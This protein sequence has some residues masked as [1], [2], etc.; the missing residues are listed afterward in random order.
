MS[1]L[2][3]QYYST[4]P[5]HNLPTQAYEDAAGYDLYAAEMRTILPHS[6]ECVGIEIH[7]AIP[8]GFFAKLFSRSGLLKDYL[9]ICEGGV[10]D[11]DFRGDLKVMLVNLSDRIFHVKTGDKIAHMVFMKKY[12]VNFKRVYDL[13]DLGMT[14]RGSSGFSLSSVIK[15]VKFDIDEESDEKSDEEQKGSLDAEKKS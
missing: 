9:V 13:D 5:E 14:K 10:I 4:N 6:C 2:N 12:K 7:F 15:K 8:A 11:S 1:C 3:V